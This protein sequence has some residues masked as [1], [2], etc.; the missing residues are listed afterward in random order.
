MSTPA[1]TIPFGK[2]LLKLTKIMFKVGILVTECSNDA[3]A[4]DAKSFVLKVGDLILSESGNAREVAQE[5]RDYKWSTVPVN[6]ASLS[7]ESSAKSFKLLE[8]VGFNRFVDFF[9][10]LW[11]YV[12]NYYNREPEVHV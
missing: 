3:V 7:L 11:M 2:T 12:F 5:L 4:L 1:R 8:Y 9:Y 6:F 10:Q